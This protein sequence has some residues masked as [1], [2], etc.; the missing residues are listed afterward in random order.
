M[1]TRAD[2]LGALEV[3]DEAGQRV[4]LGSL[5]RDK[6]VALAFIRHFG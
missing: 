3:L 4:T 1:H 2:D 5:W 6:P